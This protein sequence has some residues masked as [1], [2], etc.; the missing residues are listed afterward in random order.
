MYKCLFLLTAIAC[1]AEEPD[2][3]KISE[4]MGH[5][6]G[7]NLQSIG[8]D[9]EA[10]IQ[11][12]HDAAAGKQPPL[13]EEECVEAVA[14]LQREDLAKKQA[15]KLQAAEEFLAQN[16]QATGVVS[17]EDNKLQYKIDEPGQGS[18]VGIHHSPL[19]SFQVHGLDGHLIGESEGEEVFSLEDTLPGFGKGIV[20]MREGETRTIYIHPDLGQPQEGLCICKVTLLRADAA[21]ERPMPSLEG[22]EAIR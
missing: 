1:S 13:S 21:Q 16:K 18:P 20:G 19:L 2:V 6:I 3:V 12:L 8:V 10:V 9:L 14:A 5:L 15:E 22:L 17:I 7:K 4:S 11:G